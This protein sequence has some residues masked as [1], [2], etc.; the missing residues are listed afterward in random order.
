ML[1]LTGVTSR[2]VFSLPIVWIDEVVSISFIWV[3]MIGAALARGGD[4]ALHATCRAVAHHGA[5]ADGWP[6]V[7][8]SLALLL[9]VGGLLVSLLGGGAVLAAGAA[10]ARQVAREADALV[11]AETSS[12]SV[13]LLFDYE[14]KWLLDIQPQGADFDYFHL[15]LEFYAALRRGGLNVDVLPPDAPRE[16]NGAPRR[17]LFLPE[18]LWRE[19]IK[20]S[21][22]VA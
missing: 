12:A 19:T 10:E 14:A 5:L 8:R 2:Y 20:V 18:L 17:V 21:M 9:V 11:G 6:G 15:V 1:L 3:T 13:A 22:A 7:M 4:T 16:E